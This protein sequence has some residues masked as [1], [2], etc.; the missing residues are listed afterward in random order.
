MSDDNGKVLTTRKL[1]N[2]WARRAMEKAN[3]ERF[4]NGTVSSFDAL[5]V[6]YSQRK[7]RGKTA[8]GQGES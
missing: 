3:A 6:P 8:D 1:G 2:K 7:R 5:R 4:E